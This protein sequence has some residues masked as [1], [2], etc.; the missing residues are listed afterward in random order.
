MNHYHQIMT[1][2]VLSLTDVIDENIVDQICYELDLNED[3]HSLVNLTQV[4]QLFHHK[5]QPYLD[6]EKERR[7]LAEDKLTSREFNRI[8]LGVRTKNGELTLLDITRPIPN[9]T[10]PESLRTLIFPRSRFY[11]FGLNLIDATYINCHLQGPATIRDLYEFCHALYLRDPEKQ[12]RCITEPNIVYKYLTHV[13]MP[14]Q[15]YYYLVLCPKAVLE[16]DQ[17]IVNSTDLRRCQSFY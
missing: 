13:V 5:C 8:G 3:Y 7:R 6:R 17:L 2:H 14:G 15:N 11:S 9:T 10:N 12:S 16:K 1:E 4:N